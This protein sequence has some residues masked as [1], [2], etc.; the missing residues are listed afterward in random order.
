MIPLKTLK[1][2]QKGILRSKGLIERINKSSE[3]FEE[4]YS[5]FIMS[6]LEKRRAILVACCLNN[7]Y[8]CYASLQT[9]LNFLIWKNTNNKK[10]TK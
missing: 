9:F 3:C 4:L 2:N 5:F 10:E 8:G 7:L 1:G 6:D